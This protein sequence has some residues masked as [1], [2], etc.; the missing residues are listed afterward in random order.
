MAAEAILVAPTDRLPADMPAAMQ[1]YLTI[2]LGQ[3]S[4]AG[5]KRENQDFHGAITPEGERLVS[6]GVAIALAD[7]ISTS[8]L[9]ATASETA[10]KSFLTDY[11]CTPDS[12]TVQSSGDR[13]ISATNSWMHAQNVR[14]RPREEGEDRE[15]Q[16]LI[17][18]FSALI[19]KS[20]M[21]HLFHI[22]DAQI[23]RI[24]GG[25]LE[26]LTEAHRISAGGGHS[27]LGRAMGVGRMVEI[28]YRDMP[29]QPGDIFLLTTDGVHEMLAAAEIVAAMREADDLNHAARL[30]AEKALA[31]GSDDNLT[32]QIVRVETLPAG[33]IDD[34][35]GQD[36]R[37]A[38][39]P[40]LKAGDHF[41]CYDI[42]R[43]IHSGSRSHVF[44]AQNQKDGAR[45][46][47]KL[48]STEHAQNDAERS[49]LMLEDWVMRR[50]SHQ[51]ILAS[52]PQQQAR[53][54]LYSASEYVEGQTLDQWMHDHPE[55][56]LPVVRDIV[57][58][59]ANGLQALHRKQM[60]HRDLRPKN[61]IIDANGTV[62][63]IDFGSVQ[64]AGI[65]EIAPRAEEDAAYAGTM[66]YSAAEHYLG[67]SAST[68]SDI[69]SLGVIAYQMVTGDLPY[70]PRVSAARTPSA[71]RRLRYVPASERNLAV[72]VWMDA[73]LAKA[74]AIN[75]G[76][77]YA[78]LSEFL[79]D[80]THPNGALATP[81][82]RPLIQRG[83]VHFWRALALALA[84]AL[85]LSILTRPDIGLS[86]QSNQEETTQ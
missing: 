80:F 61:I 15:A 63:I 76:K 2:S 26:P 62:K 27:Y 32:V 71:Q 70:G 79:Y 68:Q 18:T 50:V 58:Q 67:Y 24:S 78:E 22:G 85:A 9:G 40:D 25:S 36:L 53:R 21:A 6:K 23:A 34:L 48:P 14:I 13:V 30:I 33:Q 77:R 72:P 38:N 37:L 3:Y 83:S 60:I 10:V 56:D 1:D 42:I 64:V 74:V 28:D 52:V 17:C 45:V 16:A 55:P 54:Y 43:Q 31:K 46:A 69:F 35:I 19:L 39:A 82:P 86:H 7:G 8:A 44:L 73:A 29:L 5:R 84:A 81:E 41:E 20:R 49:A 66:Q 12:W 4:T 75:P 57:R 11:Y 47:I 51:N 65:D 59:I